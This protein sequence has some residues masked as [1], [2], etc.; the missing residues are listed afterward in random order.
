MLKSCKILNENQRKEEKKWNTKRGT[1]NK[2]NKQKRI[3]K[4]VDINP[5]ISIITF[6]VSGLNTLFKIQE[7]L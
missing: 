5:A 6:D 7:L 3:M 4:M 2:R 1:K